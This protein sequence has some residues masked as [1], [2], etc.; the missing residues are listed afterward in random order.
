MQVAC[1]CTGAGVAQPRIAL[2]STECGAQ[3]AA[4]V[5]VLFAALLWEV[6]A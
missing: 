3:A 1:S 5:L 6:F 4:L 2:W